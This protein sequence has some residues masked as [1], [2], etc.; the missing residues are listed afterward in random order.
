MELAAAAAE[1]HE[2]AGSEQP[3]EDDSKFTSKTSA[4]KSDAEKIMQAYHFAKSIS[5]A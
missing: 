2:S 3:S 4:P 5:C 1:D